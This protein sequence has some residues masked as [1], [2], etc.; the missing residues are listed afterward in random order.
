MLAVLTGATRPLPQTVLTRFT[1]YPSDLAS[2][3]IPLPFLPG[4]VNID[5]LEFRVEIQRS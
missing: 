5:D 4:V 2:I 3:Q 1:R